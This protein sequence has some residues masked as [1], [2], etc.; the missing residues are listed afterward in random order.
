[1]ATQQPHSS[2][3]LSRQ[4]EPLAT[5]LRAFTDALA[6][7]P[8]LPPVQQLV[9][10]A[11]EIA[12]LVVYTLNCAGDPLGTGRHNLQGL[13]NLARRLATTADAALRDEPQ[14]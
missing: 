5:Q 10:L 13:H 11:G 9:P 7:D 6:G 14:G 4:L 8:S 1:M 12:T 3:E 2:K